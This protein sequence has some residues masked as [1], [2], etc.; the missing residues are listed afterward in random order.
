MREAHFIKLVCAA[1]HILHEPRSLERDRAVTCRDEANP[2]IPIK[3]H[4]ALSLSSSI[5]PQGQK[6][7]RAAHFIKLVCAAN[8]IRPE[9]RIPHPEI[10]KKTQKGRAVVRLTPEYRYRLKP[11]F[12]LKEHTPLSFPSIL[13]PSIRGAR[14]PCAKRTS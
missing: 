8:H 4:P 14:G 5:P 9:P 11:I 2:R 12:S 13:P 6:P 1:N 7:V 3:K 10:S